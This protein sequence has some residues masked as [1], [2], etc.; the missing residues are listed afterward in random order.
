MRAD[1][2]HHGIRSRTSNT[3]LTTIVPN[4]WRNLFP[5]LFL[6]AGRSALA[7]SCAIHLRNPGVNHI[8]EYEMRVLAKANQDFQAKAI[9]GIRTVLIALD[10]PEE[11]R[12]GLM[13]FAFSRETVGVS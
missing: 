13:G 6:Q 3:G 2:S 9:S 4:R 12:K 11:R 1:Y 5:R 8:G 10:C 7:L